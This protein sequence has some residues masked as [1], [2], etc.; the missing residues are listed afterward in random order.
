ML[1]VES[2][3]QE[4]ARLVHRALDAYLP[5]PDS[6]PRIIHDAMR[7]MV[8]GDGKRIRPIL[9]LAV[10]EMCG[11]SAEEAMLPACAIE[12][13]H[14]YSLIHDDLPALD[15]D[16]MRRGRATCHKQFGEAVAVLAGDAL[17]TFAFELLGHMEN[18]GKGLRLVREIAD[19]IGTCGMI[20]GQVRD[21]Q[22]QNVKIDLR[23]LDQIN[24]E[25]TGRL[26][27]VSCLAGAIVAGVNESQE[28][29]I[30]RFGAHLGFAFQIVDDI[31]DSEGYRK[32]MPEK[33]ARQTANNFIARAKKELET[34]GAQCEHLN[35]LADFVLERTH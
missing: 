32:L 3:L 24:R 18:A 35:R 20:G 26:I 27:Q 7:Y 22:S 28:S 2:Y 10:A 6:E 8:L 30:L 33:N 31:M 15:N 23:A 16:E 34:F 9:T 29:H 5:S 25:K 4:K 21:I 19:A 17:L 1:S 13:I 11:G 12:L 14:T